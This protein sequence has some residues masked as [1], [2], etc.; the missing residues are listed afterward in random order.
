LLIC[1]LITGF[2][3]YKFFKVDMHTAF[4]CSSPGGMSELSVLAADLGA[5][6]PK[7]AILHAMRIIT[8]VSVMPVIIHV[9]EKIFLKGN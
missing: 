7:V 8:V 5:D 9:L 6:G 4:L 2:I 3:L 1:G